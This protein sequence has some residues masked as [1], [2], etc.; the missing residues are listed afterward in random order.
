M[1]DAELVPEVAEAE[2]CGVGEMLAPTSASSTA[3]W[4]A[5]AASRMS[6]QMAQPGWPDTASSQLAACLM[7]ATIFS[8]SAGVTAVRA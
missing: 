3:R 1:A 6:V 2:G 5:P 4:L 8:S 7:S